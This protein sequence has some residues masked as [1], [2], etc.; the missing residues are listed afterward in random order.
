MRRNPLDPFGAG[1]RVL[2]ALAMLWVIAWVAH[3]VVLWLSPV[4][5]LI[6]AVALL[7][8]VWVVVFGRR[9]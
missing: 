6:I 4:V 2:T 9:R 5:P 3:Q 1:E 8:C 7:I